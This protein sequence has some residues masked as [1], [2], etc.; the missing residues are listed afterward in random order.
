[1]EGILDPAPVADMSA[2]SM[3]APSPARVYNYWLGGTD[4]LAADRTAAGRIAG[5]VPQLP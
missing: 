5:A 4:H 1:M 3:S 2:P